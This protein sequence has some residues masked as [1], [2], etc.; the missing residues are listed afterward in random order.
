[1]KTVGKCLLL[2][3][4]LNVLTSMQSPVEAETQSLSLIPSQP[5]AG[6]PFLVYTDAG[7]SR[8][9]YKWKCLVNGQ[10]FD[11][12]RV[13]YD[14]KGGWL[15][16]ESAPHG[17]YV[18][19]LVAETTGRG[20]QVFLRSF[21]VAAPTELAPTID[22]VPPPPSEEASLRASNGFTP[23][24]IAGSSPAVLSV[25]L[26]QNGQAPNADGVDL[27][28]QQRI[29]DLD[30][31]TIDVRFNETAAALAKAIRDYVKSSTQTEATLFFQDLTENVIYPVIDQV[32]GRKAID[33]WE[34]WFTDITNIGAERG[35]RP[36]NVEH[37]KAFY[38]EVAKGLDSS[39][40]KRDEEFRKQVAEYLQSIG[41]EPMAGSSGSTSRGGG[42]RRCLIR[43]LFR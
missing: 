38:Q 9:E 20:N 24:A 31:H 14:H 18:F 12:A 11:S 39:V 16:V 43:L 42:R 15:K 22:D 26:L 6:E 21:V 7:D 36:D 28:T 17:S 23:V 2:G 41:Y 19:V 40:K 13:E 32:K 5:E 8:T 30:V 1:M 34:D 35:F 29:F 3:L 27:A 25:S 37:M 4:W 33:K 10:E